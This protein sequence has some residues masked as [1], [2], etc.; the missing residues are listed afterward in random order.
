MPQRRQ[1]KFL[2]VQAVDPPLG[3]NRIGC[4]L[5]GDWFVGVRSPVQDRHLW[6]L[7]IPNY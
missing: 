7:S 2:K 5:Y 3:V 1:V 6:K 4:V